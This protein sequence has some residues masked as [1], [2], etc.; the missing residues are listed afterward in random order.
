MQGGLGPASHCSRPGSGSALSPTWEG[1]TQPAIPLTSARHPQ[2][3]QLFKEGTLIE[4]PWS[5]W[6]RPHKK[7]HL[8]SPL[9]LFLSKAIAIFLSLSP[10]LLNFSISSSTQN[11][12]VLLQ[13]LS[14][15]WDF[16]FLA[17]VRLRFSWGLRLPR[18]FHE[19][20]F[21]GLSTEFGF[22][23]VLP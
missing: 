13:S 2:V 21:P 12:P 19:S 10:D 16:I 8:A 1:A 9:Q 23:R 22:P 7:S 6:H 11:L 18:L 3:Q 5:W 20:F 17:S 14:V 4:W 15:S